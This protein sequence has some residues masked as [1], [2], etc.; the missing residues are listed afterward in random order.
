MRR[1]LLASVLAAL[2]TYLAL[3]VHRPSPDAA[4]TG[5][6]AR[7]AACVDVRVLP[8][9]GHVTDDRSPFGQ[10]AFTD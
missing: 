2:V 3:T 1:A 8:Y 6:L 10:L 5:I 7:R 4:W 9:T